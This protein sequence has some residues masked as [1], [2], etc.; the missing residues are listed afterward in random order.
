MAAWT[1]EADQ[2]RLAEHNCAVRAAAERFPEICAA[3]ADFL[4][5][6]LQS[7]LERDTYI[8]DGCNACQYTI[9]LEGPKATIRNE[10]SK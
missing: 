10:D 3:E 7:E 1:V 2:V 6:V 8:P 9:A 4:R 5:E